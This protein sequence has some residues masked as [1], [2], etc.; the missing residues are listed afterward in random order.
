MA[1]T[2]LAMLWEEECYPVLEIAAWGSAFVRVLG[3]AVEVDLLA[4]ASGQNT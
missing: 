2:V 1:T 3:G 4:E